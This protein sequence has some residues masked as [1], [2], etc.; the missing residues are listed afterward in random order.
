MNT[1]RQDHPRATPLA[2]SGRL[3]QLRNKPPLGVSRARM[4]AR[5][6]AQKRIRLHTHEAHFF[7]PRL[8]RPSHF[9]RTKFA[10]RSDRDSSSGTARE[11]CAAAVDRHGETRRWGAAGLYAQGDF[12]GGSGGDFKGACQRDCFAHRGWGRGDHRSGGGRDGDV[13]GE[14]RRRGDAAADEL[15]KSNCPG[16]Y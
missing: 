1:S 2:L 9:C 15:R 16:V 11:G 6:P 10:D 3:S 14:D 4:K 8:S 12:H 13:P 7:H 5:S